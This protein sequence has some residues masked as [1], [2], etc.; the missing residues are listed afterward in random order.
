MHADI[1]ALNQKLPIFPE[2]KHLEFGDK[3]TI[4]NFV[5]NFPPYSDF[6]FTSM[7]SYNVDESII[8]SQLNNNLVV[9]FEDYLGGKPFFSFI[10]KNNV[11]QT[12]DILLNYSIKDHFSNS[13]K[14]IPEEVINSID[15][16]NEVSYSVKEDPDNYDYMLSLPAISSLM[17]IPNTSF[18]SK[19]KLIR[20]FWRENPNIYVKVLNMQDLT[21]QNSMLQVFHE[22]KKQKGRN[23]L[24]VNHEFC[25]LE[26]LI[27]Y[28]KNLNLVTVGLFNN[29]NLIGFEINEYVANKYVMAHFAKALPQYKGI[30]EVLY[31]SIAKETYNKGYEFVN[32]E[33]DLGI[34]GLKDAKKLWRPAFL[35]KKY[36]ISKKA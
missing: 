10:G 31:V 11:N 25:A 36:I 21:M 30:F 26:R 32:I 18:Y 5:S 28:S 2:F 12:I 4:E 19:Q 16:T 35:L 7:W 1:N 13:L 15:Y 14:L 27:E 9:R 22:W 34:Q 8:I 20:K 6:N 3:T 29:E 17:E 23:D 24:E 33:Q